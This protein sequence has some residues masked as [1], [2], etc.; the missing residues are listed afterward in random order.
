MKDIENLI[1]E[2]AKL[3]NEPV[4]A[5]RDTYKM[6]GE[7]GESI[8]R[9]GIDELKKKDIGEPNPNGQEPM[10]TAMPISEELDM[11]TAQIEAMNIPQE[12]T[13]EASLV[14]DGLVN[15]T[16]SVSELIQTESSGIGKYNIPSQDF[17]LQ[18]M[19]T[20]ITPEQKMAESMNAVHKDYADFLN[21]TNQTEIRK[22]ILEP[23]FY[24]AGV[25]T[26][27]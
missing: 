26:S 8:L 14:S 9:N 3:Y 1:S 24:R 17:G 16:S 13:N 18:S 10:I 23:N 7:N 4:E 11:N 2:Y 6:L 5:V 27:C 21:N 15:P 22:F 25:G 12:E 20:G 19:N